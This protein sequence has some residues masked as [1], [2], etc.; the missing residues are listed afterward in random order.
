MNWGKFISRWVTIAL[1]SLSFGVAIRILDVNQVFYG[2]F[3]INLSEVLIISSIGYWLLKRTIYDKLF[4]NLNLNINESYP[5]KYIRD[6]SD[7]RFYLPTG[8]S[9]NSFINHLEAIR[10]YRGRDI[11]IK[12]EFDDRIRKGL[13]HLRE[14]TNY[15]NRYTGSATNYGL[16]IF[17]NI[18]VVFIT[19][20]YL[21]G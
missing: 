11:E 9:T 5:I 18:V 15:G 10:Q 8:L 17:I 7:Y 4:R 12:Y 6:G 20:Y 1:V 2:C 19:D 21:L 3:F 14:T 16:L 13:V